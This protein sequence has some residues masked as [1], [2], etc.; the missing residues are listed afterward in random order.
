MVFYYKVKLF[1]YK[2][3]YYSDL[4][5]LELFFKIDYFMKIF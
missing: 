5:I 1:Y 2:E 3:G 4:I